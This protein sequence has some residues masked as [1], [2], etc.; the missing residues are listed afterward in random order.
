[1]MKV[2]VTGA[3]GQLGKEL[4][5]LLKD[6][7]HTV[8]PFTK[9][10]LDITDRNKI[11]EMLRKIKPDFLINTAAFTQVDTCETDI[12]NAYLINGIAPYYLA[13]EAKLKKVKFIHVST[14]YVFDGNKTVPY[15]EDDDT[16]P[17]TIYGKSKL[18]GEEFA[19]VAYEE[20]TIIRTSWLYGHEGKNFVNTIKKLA[21]SPKEIRVVDDQFGSPT[22]TKDLGMA[23]KQLLTRPPGIYHVTNSGSCSWFEFASEIVK[24]LHSEAIVSPVSTE[25][26]GLATPR[27]KYSVLS[28]KKLNSNGI[29]MRNWQQG[30]QEYLAKEDDE[31]GN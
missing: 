6:D 29:Y 5:Q 15:L 11:E 20:T 28:H 19:Q 23:I 2:V 17:K 8:H 12:D 9:Q 14:D 31:S 1:M 18:L 21:G 27:P 13:C 24:C 4:V 26:Y 25:E 30:L 10:Q 3:G 16:D 22:Y 7:Y